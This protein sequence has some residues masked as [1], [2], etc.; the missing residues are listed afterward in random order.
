MKVRIQ[1]FALG[2]GNK[3]TS[4]KDLYT[5]LVKG[6]GAPD[7]SG[8]LERRIYFDDSGAHAFARGMIITVKDQKKFTKL[9]SSGGKEHIDVQNL[10]GNERIM[11]FNFFILNKES[12]IGLYQHYHQSCAPMVFGAYLQR[13]YRINLDRKLNAAINVLNNSK[14]GTASNINKAKRN[15]KGSLSFALLIRSGKLDEILKEFSKIK[16]F[17]YEFA[18]IE[19]IKDVAQPLSRYVKK[20]LE[21]VSF[22]QAYSVSDLAK[23]ISNTV[24]SA[25]LRKA[26]V[27]VENEYGDNMSVNIDNIPFDYGEYEYDD[28][29]ASLHNLELANF[30]NH[31]TFDELERICNTPQNKATFHGKLAT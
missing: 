8:A 28:I 19:A 22:G 31:S 29:A 17:R 11:E 3:L 13:R 21:K 30:S 25:V 12:G 1:G 23:A 26:R 7:K 18:E 27:D 9:I 4:L 2:A 10:L 14:E 24:K 15:H 16:S 6:S 5:E 20:R